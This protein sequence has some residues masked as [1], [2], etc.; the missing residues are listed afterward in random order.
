VTNTAAENDV[1]HLFQF[2]PR[3]VQA[4]RFKVLLSGSNTLSVRSLELYG[5]GCT[6]PL[7]PPPA[8]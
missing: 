4:V 2:A 8:P 6:L 1:P 5:S 3:P 7:P